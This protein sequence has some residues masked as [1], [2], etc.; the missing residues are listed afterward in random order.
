M[1]ARPRSPV[2]NCRGGAGP[3]AGFTISFGCQLPSRACRHS[4][5]STGAPPAPQLQAQTG[6]PSWPLCLSLRLT[7]GPNQAI[8]LAFWRSSRVL[9]FT[10][11]ALFEPDTRRRRGSAGMLTEAEFAYPARPLDRTI[12]FGNVDR[13]CAGM[14]TAPIAPARKTALRYSSRANSPQSIDS[15]RLDSWPKPLA[16]NLPA[17]RRQA[18]NRIVPPVM[19]D[20]PAALLGDW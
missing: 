14:A 18:V 6:R 5:S 11:C 20:R 4:A 9:R 19:S 12:S 7:P 1:R 3:P 2:P 15:I 8:E 17:A 10:P 13:N 16:A